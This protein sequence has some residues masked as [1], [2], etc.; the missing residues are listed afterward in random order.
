[1]KALTS[2]LLPLLFGFSVIGGPTLRLPEDGPGEL[3]LCDAL[4][5]VASGEHLEVTLSGIYSVSG[6]FGVLYDPEE[7]RCAADV[8]PS[9]HVQF[10]EGLQPDRALEQLLADT[11]RARVTF[12]GILSGPRP[13]RP[14]DPALPMAAA[15]AARI[16][17]R[18]YGHLGAYRTQVTVEA[19][20]AH[21]AVRRDEPTIGASSLSRLKSDVPLVTGGQL[22]RYPQAAQLAEIA[23]VVVI[24]FNVEKG[25]VAETFVVVGDRVLATSAREDVSTW[26]FE[27]SVTMSGRSV[28][29]FELEQ[30]RTGEDPNVHLELDLP[31][32]ARITAPLNQ[33]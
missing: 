26:R 19:V 22:P 6:H 28:F 16:G 11:G 33:W 32:F 25:R 2:S 27:E 9:T 10:A 20:L 24:G 30:R 1:M 14:D 7:R 31:A 21:E 12:K 17:N 8:Q 23:G 13:T 18:R 4:S 5:G 15:L 29:V 3:R